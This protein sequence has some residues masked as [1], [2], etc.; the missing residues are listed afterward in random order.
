[1][2]TNTIRSAAM[3][4]I[5][6]LSATPAATGAA[7]IYQNVQYRDSQGIPPGQLPPPGM[8]RVWYEGVPPGRQPRATDC[9]TAAEIA[10]RDRNARVIYGDD[11]GRRRAIPRD[12][13]LPDEYRYPRV[14]RRD[15]YPYYEVASE[16][17]YRDGYEKGVRDARKHDSF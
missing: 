6:L 11:Y 14:D 13:R 2:N 7:Q 15:R 10:A 12:S 9:R 17:G 16:V 3:L 1:M 5:G 4:A 8:C